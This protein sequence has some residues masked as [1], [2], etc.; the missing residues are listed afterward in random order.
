[1]PRRYKK[2]R[3]YKKRK[4]RRKGY[5]SLVSNYA[6]SGVSTTRIANMRYVEEITINSLTGLMGT[7][8]FS[9]NSIYD[10]NVTGAGH[11]P[12]GHDTW[13]TLYNH[14]VVLG[15]KITVKIAPKSQNSTSVVGVYLSDAA[16]PAYSNSNQ[17]QEARKGSQRM[18]SI[19]QGKPVTV[20]SKL[21]TK[22][23]FNVTDVKDNLDRLGAVIGVTPVE[24]AY[25]TIWCQGK[26][27]INADYSV[28]AQIDYIVAFSEPKDLS[29]S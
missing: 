26:S 25:Y 1:M 7:H 28:I 18:I 22:K 20:V 16:T 14:Y 27:G 3:K 6:P 8:V 21:S 23:F 10:P 17:Y 4:P 5:R 15:S 13:A 29:A 12:M 24:Q 19:E 9:A 11:Q 2:S